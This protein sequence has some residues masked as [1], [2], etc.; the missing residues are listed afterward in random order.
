MVGMRYGSVEEMVN[1]VSG[2]RS[3]FARA[4]A[5][6]KRRQEREARVKALVWP[7]KKEKVK[8]N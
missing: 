4:L 7:K 5:R 3:A 2:K 8:D 1:S 6:K